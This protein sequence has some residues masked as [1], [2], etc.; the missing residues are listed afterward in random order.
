MSTRKTESLIIP[1]EAVIFDRNGLNVAAVEN[2][3]VH[4]RKVTVARD[5]GTSI[6][7]SDGVKSGDQVILN[8]PADISEGQTVNSHTVAAPDD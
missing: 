2:G 3:V 6:E 8:P 7:V 5:R 1:A 4:I